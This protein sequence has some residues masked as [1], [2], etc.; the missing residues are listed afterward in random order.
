MNL[1][2]QGFLVV[3]TLLFAVGAQAK[4]ASEVFEAVSASVVTVQTYDVKGEAQ[5]FGSG[6]ALPDGGVAT[7]CH[8][9]EDAAKIQVVHQEVEYPATL[10]HSD[11]DRDVCA[12]TVSGLK[13]PAVVLGSTVGLKVGSRVYAVGTP[14]GLELT[15]SDG[16]ISSLRPVPGGQYLQRPHLTWV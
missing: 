5:S 7:N 11:N 16:I 10:R 15:L 12:L 3:I 9:I 14:S 6:V 4:T 13:A 8:V 1:S 2:R